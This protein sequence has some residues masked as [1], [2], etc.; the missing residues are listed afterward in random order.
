MIGT[1]NNKEQNN[2][3]VITS[4]KKISLGNETHIELSGTVA[5]TISSLDINQ[6]TVVMNL[7]DSI[8]ARIFLGSDTFR[9][10][11]RVYEKNSPKYLGK[12]MSTKDLLLLLS[13][14]KKIQ[15]ELGLPKDDKDRTVITTLSKYAE[16]SGKEFV[17][18]RT[19][20]I[21]ERL[22]IRLSIF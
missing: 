17:Q 3:S 18:N 19:I 20:D 8:N 12:V 6:N 10:F 11:V 7:N 22:I 14:D 5:D 13:K 21:P 15:I 1:N 4:I 9:M 2:S 16:N